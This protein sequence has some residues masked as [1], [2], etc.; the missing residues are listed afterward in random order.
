M[1]GRILRAQS[2]TLL[3]IVYSFTALVLLNSVARCCNTTQFF[4]KMV[5][6]YMLVCMGVGKNFFRG[7]TS[8]FFQTFFYGRPKVVKFGFYHSKLRKQHFLLK[9]SNSWHSSDTHMLVCRKSSCHTIKKPPFKKYF[10]KHNSY[11]TECFLKQW[12]E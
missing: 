5:S 2:V 10:F 8:G 7:T 1:F 9:L 11:R 12:F 3:W 4:T 6:F